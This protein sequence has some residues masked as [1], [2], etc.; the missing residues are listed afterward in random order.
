MLFSE[1]KKNTSNILAAIQQL[2]FNLE[3]A[4]GSLAREKF[5]F[6]LQQDAIYLAEFSR[7]LALTAGRLSNKS[8]STSFIQ[9]ALGAI[10]AEKE[11]H[12]Y[13]FKL[14]DVNHALLRAS[15]S[16]Y[17]YI[18]FL[19]QQASLNTVEE[20]VAALL[21]CFWIYQEVGKSLA[22]LSHPNN[23]YQ[24]WIDVYAGDDFAL[25]VAEVIAITDELSTHASIKT[26]EKMLAAFKRATQYEW[27]FWHS[28]Y[29]QEQ[30]LIE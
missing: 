17:A 30:W 21:P 13:Y 2:P 8:M 23:P 12:Q 24:A 11:L 6:Y 27:L 20:A 4:K 7:A 19:L 18:N 15:P 1:L 22:Q 3:L 16:C 28:A 14:F 10:N 5:I 26:Q 29:R 25:S 9:F